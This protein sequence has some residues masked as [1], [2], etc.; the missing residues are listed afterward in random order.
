MNFGVDKRNA[1]RAKNRFAVSRHR[2][3]W[4]SGVGWFLLIDFHMRNAY[5]FRI[6]C[7]FYHLDER[8]FWFF[9][10]LIRVPRIWNSPKIGH[11]FQEISTYLNDWNGNEL[12][13]VRTGAS[14]C[15]FVSSGGGGVSTQ[16]RPAKKRKTNRNEIHR[17]FNR[18]IKARLFLSVSRR[19]R[20]V[21]A[22]AQTLKV[23]DKMIC[24]RHTVD[25]KVMHHFVWQKHHYY[26]Y[27]SLHR[28][29]GR[30]FTASKP[31]ACDVQTHSRR[32]TAEVQRR[33]E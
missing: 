4:R 7:A 24:A 2:H 23:S 32:R 19:G 12:I 31:N 5:V 33:F 21:C 30:W 1:K 8:Y 29:K 10:C 18:L 26:I 3:Q 27:D 16:K 15:H 11:L 9:V 28:A 25:T 17:M 22:R 6:A 14:H 20:C 13:G